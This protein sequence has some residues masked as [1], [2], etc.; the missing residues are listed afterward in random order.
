MRESNLKHPHTNNND[1][2]DR[3][4]QINN[5]NKLTIFWQ[6]LIRCLF[7]FGQNYEQAFEFN[8]INRN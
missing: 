7:K 4:K 3:P 1:D 6:L 8:M 2:D 5:T